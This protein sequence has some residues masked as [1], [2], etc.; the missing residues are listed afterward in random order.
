MIAVSC[1]IYLVVNASNLFITFINHC[2]LKKNNK[3]PQSNQSVNAENQI[4][5]VSP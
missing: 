3:S 2:Q 1:I 5:T 4:P